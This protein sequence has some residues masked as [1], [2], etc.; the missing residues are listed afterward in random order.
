MKVVPVLRH[1]DEQTIKEIPYGYE[2]AEGYLSDD[3]FLFATKSEALQHDAQEKF[4]VDCL[5][6]IQKELYLDSKDETIHIKDLVTCLI[7]SREFAT[8]LQTMLHF[9][10]KAKE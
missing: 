7:D 4:N 8:T 10:T 1:I 6:L 3:E 2:I 5:A 9:L